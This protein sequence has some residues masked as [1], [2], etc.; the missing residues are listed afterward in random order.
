MIKYLVILIALITGGCNTNPVVNSSAKKLKKAL[1]TLEA[2]TV[3]NPE[4][5]DK[6]SPRFDPN[7]SQAIDRL[8][9]SAKANVIE[10]E[11]ASE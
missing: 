4:Y 9:N 10:I 11:N 6:N 3:P 1:E 8:W 7:A 2:A 5:S